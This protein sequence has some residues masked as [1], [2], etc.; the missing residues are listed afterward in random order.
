MPTNDQLIDQMLREGAGM[1]TTATMLNRPP[2]HVCG[3]EQARAYIEM[4]VPDVGQVA[5]CI[6]CANERYQGEEEPRWVD[7]DDPEVSSTNIQ[8]G[9]YRF[10]PK[11][12]WEAGNSPF[13]EPRYPPRP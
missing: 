9:P 12:P 6:R 11:P 10:L 7:P 8:I 2:C 13:G 5:A 3:R 4:T 1:M